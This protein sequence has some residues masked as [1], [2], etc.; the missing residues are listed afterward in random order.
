MKSRLW[1]LALL[2]I[3]LLGACG[4]AATNTLALTEDDNGRA[5]T[6]KPGQV[7]VIHLAANPTTGYTWALGEVNEGVLRQAGEAGY[8]PAP[9][10][11]GEVGT[12]G[13]AVWRFVA[14]GIGTT[15]LKL[16]YIRPWEKPPKA[17]QTFSLTVT[18][19]P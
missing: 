11:Q 7:L 4:R 14:V 18:V 2:G 9:A 17:A 6:L 13:T 5:L 10:G 8:T 12:G 19:K 3:L 1:M 16:V 15:T